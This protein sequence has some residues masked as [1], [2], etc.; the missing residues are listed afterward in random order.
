MANIDTF[1]AGLFEFVDW[2]KGWLILAFVLIMADLRF[3]ILAAYKRK[4]IVRKYNAIRRTF[5]KISNYIIW[6]T[7]AYTIGAVIT[8]P[9]DIDLPVWILI[10]V[11]AIELGSI[12]NNFL[13]VVGVK[14]E[15]DIWKFIFKDTNIIKDKEDKK[16]KKEENNLFKDLDK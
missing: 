3:G 5:N 9:F 16:D 14:K 1:F 13:M 2:I 12:A 8:V 11:Y 15:I 10:A 7:V 4:E 6:L